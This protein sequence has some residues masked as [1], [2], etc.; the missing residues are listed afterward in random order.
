[1]NGSHQ[2]HG[3]SK[4]MKNNIH[5]KVPTTAEPPNEF[6]SAWYGRY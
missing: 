4:F 5:I 1:M 6:I 3:P 2:T